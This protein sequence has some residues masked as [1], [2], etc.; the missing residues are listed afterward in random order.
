MLLTSDRSRV[1]AGLH[2]F[3]GTCIITSILAMRN[4][5]ADPLVEILIFEWIC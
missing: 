1:H 3:A 5:P 4:V 2:S